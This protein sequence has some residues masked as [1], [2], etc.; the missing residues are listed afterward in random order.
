MAVTLF[1][2]ASAVS[3]AECELPLPAKNQSVN[4]YLMLINRGDERS[5]AAQAHAALRDLIEYTPMGCGDA[6]P[7]DAYRS[8]RIRTATRDV[9]GCSWLRLGIVPP[10]ATAD[11][12]PTSVLCAPASARIGG[13]S[14]RFVPPETAGRR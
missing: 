9:N 14:C 13:W 2:T 7:D 11:R 6:E 12:P 8:F 1:L 10:R 4:D 3:A 5:T